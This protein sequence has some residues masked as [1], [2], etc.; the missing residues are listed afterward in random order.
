MSKVV[1]FNLPGASGHVN[2]AISIVEE[3]VERGEQ[4]IFYASEEFRDRF[5][6][7][8]VEFRT[9]KKWTDH[10]ITDEITHD[11]LPTVLTQFDML[12]EV[13]HPLMKLTREDA[14]DYII[15]DSVCIWG[16]FIAQALGV[17]AISCITM[18]VSHPF[19]M[20]TD[21]RISA[22]VVKTLIMGLPHAM[23]ARRMLK[24]TL[25]SIG[26]KYRG[27]FFHVFDFFASI[28]DLNI[29]Y[30]AK[31]F[32]PYAN[33]LIGNFK[34]IG[35]S[36]RENRDHSDIDFSQFKRSKLIYISMGTI[37]FNTEDFYRLCFQS[38]GDQNVD[39]ILSV[40][41]T[42]DIQ[43]LGKV[44][45]N[46][47]LRHSV[48]QLEVLKHA[49]L[50]ISHGG[51]N[52]IN[53]S[54]YFGVPLVI[55]PQQ[56]EQHFN[57]RRMAKIGVAQV[58]RPEVITLEKLRAAVNH[59]LSEPSYQHKAQEAGEQFRRSGGYRSAVEAILNL[60]NKQ[61]G[62]SVSRSVTV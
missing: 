58:I 29:V 60:V 17:P 1:F 57:G 62:S 32:Q 20:V 41:K 23:W 36:F 28:G 31:A 53:E 44:P 51:M 45:D 9:Y 11:I 27:A 37:N 54:L 15:Y 14:P 7:L 19:I 40:G 39:I 18:V 5:S 48:P 30:N 47:L 3:L 42:T 21:W 59:L 46:F 50:F 24:E 43:S 56:F 12:L 55:V 4:V 25:E 16:K 26:L 49:D 6:D 52:S 35:T 22:R 2:P 33:N 10:E 61:N 8:D 34:F 13:I 38:F